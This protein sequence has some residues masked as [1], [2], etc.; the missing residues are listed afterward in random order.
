[1]SPTPEP[2]PAPTAWVAS[3]IE[4]IEA[5]DTPDAERPAHHL[6][7]DL[8]VTGPVVSAHLYATAHGIYEAFLNGTRV[9]DHEL[10][11]GVHRLPQADPGAALRRHPP[12]RGGAQ[13]PRRVC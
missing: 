3:W 9:G 8:D 6:A 5:P 10:D 7:G 12:R 11:P 13:H 1:M 2:P 4:P